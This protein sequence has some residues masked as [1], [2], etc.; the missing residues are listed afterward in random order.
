MGRH[1]ADF[2]TLEDI[3]GQPVH[4]FLPAEDW[5]A[6]LTKNG[7]Q[8]SY[9]TD[10]NENPG[11]IFVVVKNAEGYATGRWVDPNKPYD[12]AI[13]NQDYEG[14]L[15]LADEALEKNPQDPGALFDKAYAMSF[16]NRPEETIA[17]Y[18]QVL[19]LDPNNASALNNKALELSKLGREDEAFAHLQKAHTADPQ[20]L[21]IKSNLAWSHYARGNTAEF[22]RMMGEV[23][24]SNPSSL[25]N[26]LFLHNLK[27]DT[28]WNSKTDFMNRGQAPEA[29]N[30]NTPDVH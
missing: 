24:D 1:S 12:L 28:G 11:K 20:S 30:D 26:R 19:A 14:A 10:E 27:Q 13:L 3:L 16:L 25:E 29:D 9:L 4:P 21:I 5:A 22:E 7:D 2:R 17:L 8:I 6:V 15:K 18:D 23:L